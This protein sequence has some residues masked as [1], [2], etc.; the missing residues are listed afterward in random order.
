[1]VRLGSARRERSSAVV[2]ARRGST[3]ERPRA[4]C[5]RGVSCD[6]RAGEFGNEALSSKY[7]RILFAL[8][9]KVKRLSEQVVNCSDRPRRLLTHVHTPAAIRAGWRTRWRGG[10]PSFSGALLPALSPR[11]AVERVA[12]GRRRTRGRSRRTRARPSARAGWP[13]GDHVSR[14]ADHDLDA[15]RP[16]TCGSPTRSR[17]RRRHPKAGPSSSQA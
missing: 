8:V 14:R 17:S 5:S 11:R 6:D 12:L 16:S 10:S 9:Q 3:L 1:M 13:G 15:A 7:P 4:V 2:T